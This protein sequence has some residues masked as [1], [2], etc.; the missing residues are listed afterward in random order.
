MDSAGGQRACGPQSGPGLEQGGGSEGGHG[1]AGSR[2]RVRFPEP[3]R[4]HSGAPLGLWD[5]GPTRDRN[6]VR[7]RRLAHRAQGVIINRL[8]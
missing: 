2:S 8:K 4:R 5:L 1:P 3:P 6:G 7:T